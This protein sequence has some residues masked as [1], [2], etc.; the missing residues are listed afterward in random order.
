MHVLLLLALL[1]TALSYVPLEEH[2]AN[3]FERK[4]PRNNLLDINDGFLLKPLLRP[5]VSGTEGATEVVNF[6]KGYLSHNLSN[7]KVEEDR[8]TAT[9]PLA[10]VEFVNL[11]ATMDP[12]GVPPEDVGHIVLAAH[13]DSKRL[14]AGFIGAVDSAV[15][16]AILLYIAEML[17]AQAPQFW[18]KPLRTS[19]KLE[20]EKA[21]GVQLIFFDGEEAVLDWTDTDSIYGAR[22]LAQ[23]WEEEKLRPKPTSGRRNRLQGIDLFVLLDLLGAPGT[24][25][26]SFFPTT[27]W[28]FE[29]L[30]RIE[31]L[32][33]DQKLLRVKE[34]HDPVFDASRKMFQSAGHIGDDHIPFWK[35]GVEILHIIPVPFPQVWHTMQD[36]ASALDQD[37]IYD[38]AHIFCQFT[39]E[40][41][42]MSRMFNKWAVL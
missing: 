35:K 42:E 19:D 28:A 23:K 39:A 25:V 24:T 37:A 6:L 3:V 13:Y 21:L 29:Q 22:H 4:L 5:R 7:W 36:D 32:L 16:C 38:L 33:L 26:S 15:P 30:A 27:H 11:I 18:E 40:W 31:K 1:Q 9:T 8:F 10:E 14:P 12:P 20:V 41:L 17:S 34:E 2:A